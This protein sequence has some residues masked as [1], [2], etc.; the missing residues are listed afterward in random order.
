MVGPH[1]D[2]EISQ[3]RKIAFRRLFQ[4]RDLLDEVEASFVEFSC[5]T[6]RFGGYAVVGDRGVKMSYNFWETH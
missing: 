5:A 6:E 2:G 1:M 3:G 4:N